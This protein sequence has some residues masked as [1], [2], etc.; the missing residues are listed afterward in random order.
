MHPVDATGC[1]AH[2]LPMPD[3]VRRDGGVFV[4]VAAAGI[5]IQTLRPGR[6]IEAEATSSG[7]STP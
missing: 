7:S 1:P 2:S 3:Q 5:Q 4:I 6:G